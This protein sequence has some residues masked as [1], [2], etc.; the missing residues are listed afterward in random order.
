[1]S[2]VCVCSGKIPCPI[3]VSRNTPPRLW[4]MSA[5]KR[6]EKNG[7]TALKVRLL[8]L[9]TNPCVVTLPHLTGFSPGTPT[10]VKGLTAI[11]FYFI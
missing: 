1:M 8:T 4:S 3:S 7:G 5:V 2:F 11:C 10:P 6:R 9:P